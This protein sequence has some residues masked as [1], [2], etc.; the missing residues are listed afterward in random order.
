M[1]T[2]PD[3]IIPDHETPALTQADSHNTA[4]SYETEPSE[5]NEIEFWKRLF[6]HM[7]QESRRRNEINK[8]QHSFWER[9]MSK[10]GS[11][12]AVFDAWDNFTTE[13]GL[14]PKYKNPSDPKHREYLKSI[15]PKRTV[16]VEPTNDTE[17]IGGSESAVFPATD[18]P[19]EVTREKL[20][21]SIQ[22]C[23]RQNT[24]PAEQCDYWES[25]ANKADSMDELRDVWLSY[26]IK[27]P[28]LEYQNLSKQKSTEKPRPVL[29]AASTRERMRKIVEET[30]M[31]DNKSAS[32]LRKLNNADTAEGL[33][34][35]TTPSGKR[36]REGWPFK[37]FVPYPTPKTSSKPTSQRTPSGVVIR[38]KDT[39]RDFAR[40]DRHLDPRTAIESGK[41]GSGTLPFSNRFPRRETP[42]VTDT[43][44]F[45]RFLLG[46]RQE[47]N[48]D[49][50]QD[51]SGK[52]PSHVP[53]DTGKQQRPPAKQQPRRRAL[54]ASRPK[55]TGGTG[56]SDSGSDTDGPEF[57]DPDKR[58][59]PASE[60]DVWETPSE[61][62]SSGIFGGSGEDDDDGARDYDWEPTMPREME[63][64]EEEGDDQE[65]K[66]DEEEVDIEEETEIE[67]VT[68]TE[69]EEDS[70]EQE[71]ETD[72]EDEEDVFTDIEEEEYAEDDRE[73]ER[74]GGAKDHIS[75]SSSRE[76][77]PLSESEND[78]DETLS[79]L[80]VGSR[81]LGSDDGEYN[82][83]FE[84]EDNDE[85]EPNNSES[86]D[87]GSSS[88]SSNSPADR[89]KRRHSSNSSSSNSLS[90]SKIEEK[91]EA[92]PDAL[93]SYLKLS[94]QRYIAYWALHDGIT[95]TQS[96][97]YTRRL[98]KC[99]S[100]GYADVEEDVIEQL[101][102][103]Q[104]ERLRDADPERHAWLAQ[105]FA[106]E[107]VPGV[108]GKHDWTRFVEPPC[109]TRKGGCAVCAEKVRDGVTVS[110]FYG[111]PG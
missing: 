39:S 84:E 41:R 64:D 68:D 42:K 108:G 96:A 13:I 98:A 82:D 104:L 18:P 3:E 8:W 110:S 105:T 61:D 32:W 89:P 101:L 35:D 58:K 15:D 30:Q 87:Y 100:G 20:F 37:P 69:E 81:Y 79:R 16:P 60:D 99:N 49:G 34:N 14:P 28:P 71:K 90:S 21:R 2:V 52:K 50:T 55:K 26:R 86:T 75:I 63:V 74:D 73:E 62:S 93:P 111:G 56:S 6:P 27:I 9:Q 95:P 65:K 22:R 24:L 5:D 1:D 72:D 36:D 76:S 103:R 23:R 44:Q 25:Q 10:A 102:E 4:P 88:S 106:D 97:E 109:D 12:S 19:I 85:D 7:L 11:E 38:A 54:N 70:D 66:G 46:A 47:A 45:D 43:S 67:E 17:K 40:K 57:V 51:A 94:L 107:W 59:A 31:T 92:V 91:E 48:R 78:N 77:S 83:L 33:L 80:D 53:K 29:R